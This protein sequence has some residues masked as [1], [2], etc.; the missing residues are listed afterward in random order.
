VFASGYR[1]DLGKVP[2]LA[3]LLTEVELSNGFPV[4]DNAFQTS[5]HGLYLT[6]FSA[7]QDFGPFFGFVKGAPAAATLI[8][9]DLLSRN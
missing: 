5:V 4:L 6:G 2:Y 1:A 3:G 7:T 8:V 9:R